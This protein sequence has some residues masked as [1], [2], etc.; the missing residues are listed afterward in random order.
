MIL[1]PLLRTGECWTP[2][3]KPR[4]P[5]FRPSKPCIIPAH[6]DD[7][8]KSAEEEDVEADPDYEDPLAGNHLRVP[9]HDSD[10][11]LADDDENAGSACTDCRLHTM[12]IHDIRH[13]TLCTSH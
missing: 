7:D 2:P 1:L 8:D 4:A 9:T 12:R 5:T 6:T 10:D 3:P 11:D 13:A